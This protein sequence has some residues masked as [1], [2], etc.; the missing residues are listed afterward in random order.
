MTA[1]T[2]LS[3]AFRRCTLLIIPRLMSEFAI[4]DWRAAAAVGNLAY[5]CGGFEH[6]QEIKPVV[7]GSRGGYGWAQWTGPRRRT[8]EQWCSDHKLPPSSDDANLGYLLLELHQ[9]YSRAITALRRAKTFQAAVMAFE[10][11]YEAAGVKNYSGRQKWADKA[12]ALWRSLPK[13]A[14]IPVSD[15]PNHPE[16]DLEPEITTGPE[17]ETPPAPVPQPPVPSQIAV[18]APAVPGAQPQQALVQGTSGNSLL[19]MVKNAVQTAANLHPQI[20]ATQAVSVA[21][22]AVDEL[23][24]LPEFQKLAGSETAWYQQRSKWATIIGGVTV[25]GVPLLKSFGVDLNISP[26][27]VDQA[28]NVLGASGTAVAAYLAY[29]AGTAKRPLFSKADDPRDAVIAQQNALMQ[30]LADRIAA[31]GNST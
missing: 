30:K 6:Y 8:Y 20:G 24:K 28:S 4:A 21:A 11:A 26:T 31:L 14:A 15:H 18:V 5:E 13:A 25:V 23:R 3:P 16:V 1:I 22:A 9:E 29:R 19:D 17:T 12:I 27:M 10:E 2:S 7:E